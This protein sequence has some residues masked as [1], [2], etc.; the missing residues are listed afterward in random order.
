MRAD[1]PEE[2]STPAAASTAAA[3]GSREVVRTAA[4]G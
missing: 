1:R 4:A 3:A 2:G